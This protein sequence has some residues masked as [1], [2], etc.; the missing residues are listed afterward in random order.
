MRYNR[1]RHFLLKKLSEKFIQNSE[2]SSVNAD[3]IGLS[4]AEIDLLLKRNK[5]TRELVLSELEKSEEIVFYNLKEKGCF[6]EP[7]N[8]I[9]AFTEKKY[10]RRNEDI[11][12]NW[13]KNIVQIFIPIASLIIAYLALTLKINTFQKSNSKEVEKLE[14]KI[15][16]LEKKTTE[17]E[18]KNI[19]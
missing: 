13:L 9:S 14:M 11:I 8:G 1:T 18:R 12:I 16:S 5:K 6:I 10:L 3:I 4:Y 19:R 15:K 2:N 17:K 7:K